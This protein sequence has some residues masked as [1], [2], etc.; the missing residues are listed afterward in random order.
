MYKPKIIK[1]LKIKYDG[2]E[3][4]KIIYMHCSDEGLHFENQ[5]NEFTTTNINCKIKDVKFING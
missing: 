1:G 5:D 3:Y 2:K 4:D